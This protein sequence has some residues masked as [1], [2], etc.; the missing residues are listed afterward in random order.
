[1][2]LGL[3][4]VFKGDR[5]YA[6]L[7][8]VII[9]IGAG[10][11]FFNLGTKSLWYD[12]MLTWNEAKASFPILLHYMNM[13]E[14]APFLTPFLIGRVIIFNDSEF[15]IR[16]L[17]CIVGICSIIVLYFFSR[18]FLSKAASL[19]CSL[20]LAFSSVQIERS[21]DARY[22][23]LV[24]FLSIFVLWAFIRYFRFPSIKNLAWFLVASLLFLFTYYSY[25]LFF[26]ALNLVFFSCVFQGKFSRKESSRWILSQVVLM[27][28]IVFLWFLQMR[29]QVAKYAAGSPGF[30]AAGFPQQNSLL[31]YWKFVTTTTWKLFDYFYANNFYVTLILVAFFVIGFFYLARDRRRSI[32]VVLFVCVLTINIILALLGKFLYIAH[33]HCLHLSPFY[34]LFVAAGF[35]RMFFQQQ[36]RRL[37][38]RVLFIAL[39]CFFFLWLD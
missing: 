22:Y 35:E 24:V 38:A 7:L 6:L 21:Q 16:L 10:L 4:K 33:R 19:L 25:L 36:Q 34:Y 18:E 8:V 26:V 3:R 15:F 28:G 1:M 14:G 32:V 5:K 37:A 27:I 17:P 20:F 2:N 30:M 9:F 12:E 11:R 39:V 13:W 23:P 29:F 31:A